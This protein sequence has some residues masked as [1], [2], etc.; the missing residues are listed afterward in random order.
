MSVPPERDFYET[1]LPQFEAAVRDGHVG[2]VMGAYNSVYGKP[3]CANPLLLTDLLRKQW[4]FDGHVVSDCGAI[5]D[6]YANHKFADTPEA[7]AALAVKAGDDLCCGTDYNSLL[8]AVRKGLITE[9]EI[10][11]AVSRVL[12]A[13]FRLGLFDPPEQVAYAQIPISQNDTPEHEALALQV[14]RQS[15]VLLKNDG[16]LPLDRAKIKR[17]AV[18]GANAISVPMLL[19]NYNGT[20][21]RPVTILAGIKS[22]AGTNIEVA[23]EPACPLALRQDGTDKPDAEMWTSAIAAAWNVGRDHLRWRHQPAAGRRGNESGLRRL[24]RRRPHANRIAAGA[25]RIA[26]GVAGHRQAR[27]V[28]QLQR[29][30]HRHAV[31][32]RRTCPRFCRRGIRANR[33]DAPWPM[34]CSAT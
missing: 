30:R 4:G 25:N 19:G 7:A 14:A 1:Y 26:Q 31:G 10:D 24:Q 12:E 28:C 20:P 22:V 16:L 2:A 32:G 27:R 23:Y 9:K 5:Y 15:I 29:Q 17:I 18:I 11:A 13:R 8:R 34:F 33:A 3:A 21:A 6:I